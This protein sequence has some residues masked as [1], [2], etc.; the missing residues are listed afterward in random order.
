VGD[1]VLPESA[2]WDDYYRPLEARLEELE[3]TY[4]GDPVAERGLAAHRDEIAM[5]RQ[6]S[7]FYGYVFFVMKR[8]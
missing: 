3:R 4:A 7:S 5:Y 6:M 1:F 8:A 2:W